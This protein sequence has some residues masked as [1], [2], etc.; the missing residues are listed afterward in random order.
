MNAPSCSGG[1]Y[2]CPKCHKMGMTIGE[3]IDHVKTCE[4]ETEV[5]R[6]VPL[7]GPDGYERCPQ[8]GHYDVACWAEDGESPDADYWECET[9]SGGCGASGD[10]PKVA[11]TREP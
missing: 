9:F 10:F 7:T 2:G 4:V 1:V 5:D 11:A 6:T 8:C 3:C